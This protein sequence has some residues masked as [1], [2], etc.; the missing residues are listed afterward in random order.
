M[1]AAYGAFLFTKIGR[2]YWD[3][4]ELPSPVRG[5]VGSF[6][7]QSCLTFVPYLGRSRPRVPSPRDAK[8]RPLHPA[9]A[10]VAPRRSTP[11][12]WWI[13]SDSSSESSDILGRFIHTR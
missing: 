3:R 5:R 12:K 13:C 9:E 7:A 6:L 1:R 11:L 2:C 4:T 10:D 8:M